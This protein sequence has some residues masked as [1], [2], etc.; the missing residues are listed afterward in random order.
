MSLETSVV[1][2]GEVN[3]MVDCEKI[4]SYVIGEVSYKP[5]SL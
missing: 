2:T 3:V 5:I 1:I 4:I